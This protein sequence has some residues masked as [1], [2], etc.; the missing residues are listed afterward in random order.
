MR[1]L[2]RSIQTY[3]WIAA[4][5]FVC[6]TNARAATTSP[7]ENRFSAL[8]ASA[9]Y[10][11]ALASNAGNEKLDE[12]IRKSQE[13]VRQSVDPRPQLERLG[14]LYVAKARASHDPG[15]YRLAE[16]CALAL[17]AA[18]TKSSEALLLRGHVAQSLHRFKDAE[19]IARKLTAQRELAFDHGLLGD[20]LVDQGKVAEAI[21]EYQ[22]MVDLR[23]DL[24]S[25]SRV[26]HMRW[27]KSDL[28]GAIEAAELA[29]A[30]GSPADAES[31]AWACTRLASYQFQ[32]GEKLK[33]ESACKT[34]LDFAKDYPPALLL[35]GRMLLPG[36]NP[37]AAA[38]MIRRAAAKNP[39]PEYQWALADS[40]REAGKIEEAR[41]V[42]AELNRS[43]TAND[44]RTF[45]LFLAT[46]GEQASLA[47]RLAER[48]LEDRRDVFTHDALAWALFA[49]GRYNDAWAAMGQA[50]AEGTKDARLFLH[51]GVIASR[52]KREDAEGWLSRARELDRLL[53][54]SER[55]HL[56]QCLQLSLRAKAKLSGPRA[57][58]H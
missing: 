34:A 17:E 29:V 18:D 50:L 24:Q 58:V 12:Q 49:A 41:I 22:R 46:R 30:A 53:L 57:D 28:F 19:F 21:A 9:A 37:A 55:R 42:E 31:A 54:P 32:A 11:I 47:L 44:P 52:L 7:S 1:I 6:A 20:A 8:R 16:Q 10:K 51:A 56:Q 35:R 3:F 25:Y 38:E 48:E 43:G 15:F 13:A 39:L 5:A 2:F 14:W 45:A 36:G 33:A 23:P 4:T 26:A 27:L 40:L